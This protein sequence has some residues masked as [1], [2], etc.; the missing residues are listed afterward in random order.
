VEDFLVPVCTMGMKV[1]ETVRVGGS[2]GTVLAVDGDLMLVRWHEES[3][4]QEEWVCWVA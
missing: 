3:P 4:D 1:G 2:V